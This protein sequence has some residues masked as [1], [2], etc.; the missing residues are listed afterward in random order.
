M[1]GWG[2][3]IS[4]GSAY[5]AMGY[6]WM[7]LFPALF[8]TVTLLTLNFIGNAMRHALDPKSKR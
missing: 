5:I 2:E 6:W 1:T 4:D 3:M 8:L 7:L